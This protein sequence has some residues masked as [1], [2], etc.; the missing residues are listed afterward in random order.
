MTKNLHIDLVGEKMIITVRLDATIIITNTTTGREIEVVLKTKC[1]LTCNET[2]LD[3][4]TKTKKKE[5]TIAEKAVPDTL[6]L[7]V[8]KSV[9]KP[10]E[11]HPRVPGDLT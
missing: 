10:I 6:K 3:T 8:S 1:F 5:T 7:K 11:K 4:M 2:I 9:C